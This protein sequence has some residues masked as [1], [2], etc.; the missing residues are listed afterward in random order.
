VSNKEIASRLFIASRT[1][2]THVDHILTKLG[3]TS[4][5]QIAAWVME[6]RSTTSPSE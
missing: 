1:A 6:N 3:F 5:V 4:R 2:E